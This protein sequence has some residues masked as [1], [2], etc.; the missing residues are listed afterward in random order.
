MK[1][2]GL[3]HWLR[4]V[5]LLFLLKVRIQVSS[6]S[7]SR[8]L[9]STKQSIKQCRKKRK[10]GFKVQKQRLFYTNQDSKFENIDF[11]ELR[12]KKKKKKKEKLTED[13]SLREITA[14][15][16]RRRRKSNNW[17]ARLGVE[18]EIQ[19]LW[20]IHHQLLFRNNSAA[21][22]LQ[23]QNPSLSRSL[24]LSLSL[25]LNFFTYKMSNHG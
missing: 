7:F 25:S 20:W 21:S 2:V 13:Q 4:W 9:S 23:A 14:V 15:G 6:S 8:T 19:R 1:E 16:G 24:S 18:K 17:T 10:C 5:K 22:S 11:W 12:L 3:I